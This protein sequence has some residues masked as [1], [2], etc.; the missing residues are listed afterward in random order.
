MLCQN[1]NNDMTSWSLSPSSAHLTSRFPHIQSMRSRN[2]IQ[3]NF[4]DIYLPQYTYQRTGGHIS[5]IFFFHI[6]YTLEM[7][8]LNFNQKLF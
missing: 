5:N 2:F 8:T 1:S 4:L 7:L 3:P 6:F